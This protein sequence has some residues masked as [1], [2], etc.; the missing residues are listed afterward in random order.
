MIERQ[1]LFDKIQGALAHNRVVGLL[2]PRQC[3]KTTLARRIVAPGSVNYFDLEDARHLQRL[4]QP[5]TAMEALRGVVVIDEVQR[6]PEIFAALRVLADRVP[7]PA[8]FLVLGSSAPELLRQTSESLA[9][10]IARVT[11]GGLSLSDVG[12]QDRT[13]HWLR[14]GYPLSFL[15]EDDGL[16]GQWRR[17]FA[18]TFLER[19]VPQFGYMIPATALGRFWTMVAHYHGQIFNGAEFARSLGISQSSVRR[20]LDLLT[21]L[22]MIRQLPAWHANLKKRQVK[23]PKIFFRDSGLLHH[24]LGIKSETEL[25]SHPKCGAS[26]EGYVIEETLQAVAPDEAYFWA[27]HQGAELDLL[28][29]KDGRMLG[30]ECKRV[31][32]PHLTP[33]MRIA[34]E[35][36]KLERLAVVYPGPL[37]YA[38]ADRVEAVPLTQV[39][40]GLAG[41]FP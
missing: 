20:Y 32:A 11:M 4:V 5:M 39:T 21:D 41:L 26:W 38:L 6:S 28:M 2:G 31:D 34:L 36:L 40:R 13:A 25:M 18:Q 33:S 29:I 30:L 35:D 3:G 12:P 1:Q 16:S 14:G 24:F 37:R 8:K 27:T 17:D 15:A 19:D 22:F 23:A 10:R 7:L 9:G